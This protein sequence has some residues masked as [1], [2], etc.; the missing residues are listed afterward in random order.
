MGVLSQDAFLNELTKLYDDNKLKGS[1]TITM[2]QV[3]PNLL[4]K[5]RRKDEKLAIGDDQSPYCLVRAVGRNKKKISTV[6]PAKD[7]KRFHGMF[8]NI[9]KVHMDSLKKREKKK[10]TKADKK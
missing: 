1:V 10:K 8:S 6:V 3:R 5:S 2:K 4:N 7:Q 9:I